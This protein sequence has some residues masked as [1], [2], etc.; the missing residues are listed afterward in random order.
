MDLRGLGNS[1]VTFTSYL[2]EQSG[3]DIV[4]LI[5]Q[6]ANAKSGVVLIGNSFAG[7]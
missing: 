5:D 4:Q 1:D 7:A 3:N 6:E 2:P